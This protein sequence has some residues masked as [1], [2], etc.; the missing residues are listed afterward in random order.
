MK[1][2]SRILSVLIAVF[3]VLAV[4]GCA[5]ETESTTPNVDRIKAAG[6]LVM[7][8][9][10]A[11][12]PFEY[13]GPDG[14]V[15]GV[16]VDIAQAVADKLGVSLKV[17]D[18]DFDGIILAVQS[19]QGD[20]GAAG[21]TNNEERRESV[22]FSIDYVAT[23]QLIIV[24]EGSGYKTADDLAGK[25]IGVQMGTTG[26]IYAEDIADAQINRF[27]T[28]PDAGLALA[29]GKID[30]VVI[31]A[32][33]AAQIASANAGLVILEEPLT[34]ENY[35]I[36]IKK[37]NADLKAVIDEVLQGMLDDGTLQNIIDHH[38]EIGAQ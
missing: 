6:E 11:F 7:L 13:L 35:A 16:D 26:D 30:A 27:K 9:N 29:S 23:S 31:D 19:G 21:I 28:G 3:M 15:V 37:G 25:Q 2:Q 22:D 38:V 17:V 32:M 4:V 18:M 36:A 14:E 24:Q 33:P 10:A 5:K 34:D 8:T 12:P 1:L 20:I